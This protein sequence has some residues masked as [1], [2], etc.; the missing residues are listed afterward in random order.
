MPILTL[1]QAG[2][3]CQWITDSQRLILEHFDLVHDS[4][5]HIYHSALQ[6]SPSSSWLHQCYSAELS[7]G[8]KVVKGFLPEW[9]ECFRTIPLAHN[10]LV[11]ACW[12][13]TI[14]VGS[15]SYHIIILDAITG[16]QVAILSGHATWVGSLTF[17]A[18]G[19]LL[20]SGS[21]DKTVKLWDIQTGGVA[22][23]FYGHTSYIFS[24]SISADCTTIASGSEDN[25]ICLWD[26]KSEECYH[27]IEQQKPVNCVHFFPMDPQHLISISG[28]KVWQWN[29]NGHQITPTYDG[30]HVSFSLDGTQFALCSGTVVRVQNSSSRVVVA[31]FHM[32]NSE[33]RSCCFSPDGRLIAVAAGNTAYIWDITSSDPHPLKTFIGHAK[34]ISLAFSS[35]S[36]LISASADQSVKFWQIGTLPVVSAMADPKSVPLASVPIK[37]ITLQAKDGI[38]IS[39]DLD[40][41]VKIWDIFT[42]LCKASFQTP[43][44]DSCQR[45]VQLINN[46]LICAWHGDKK[47]HILDIEK[48]KLQ[49]VDVPGD[50]VK[51]LRISGDGSKVFCLY[52]TSIQAW[53]ILTGEVVGRVGLL[54]ITS[55]D[56]FLT[57]DGSRVWL[58]FYYGTIGIGGWDFGILGSPI[59]LFS[60]ALKR[61]HL[62]FVGGIRKKRSFLPKIKDIVTGKEVFQLPGRLV[63]PVDAQ[64]DGRYL[65]AGYDSGE[66]LILD[67]NYVPLH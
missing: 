45:D 48:K 20:V 40:G 14:A 36:S 21:Y 23:T 30:S 44:R 64:W 62:D 9:G 29:T 35:S 58:N 50:N 67:C 22:T 6:F 42:G 46:S 32:R 49:M 51:D 1:I 13:D 63:R 25:T 47:I 60:E 18:D 24:V 8:V 39:S 41:V 31:E 33:T 61:P 16:S 19:R 15:R 28:G 10:P 65:V 54:P 7:Q 11:L 59:Q 5:S 3:P 66:V 56:P 57:I 27:I 52:E 53:S 26:T 34:I 2:G 55:Q 17:S 38:T 43:A 12:K 37:S 4:P